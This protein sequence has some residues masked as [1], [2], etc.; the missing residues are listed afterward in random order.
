MNHTSRASNY[1]MS[2]L[3][4]NFMGPNA[5]LMIDELTRDSGLAK[6]MRILDLGCGRD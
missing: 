5:I 1:D 6:G 4:L 3:S 2:F